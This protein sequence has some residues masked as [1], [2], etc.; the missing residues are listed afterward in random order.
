MQ[1]HYCCDE[2][3][4]LPPTKLPPEPPLPAAGAT[5]GADQR[6]PPQR[7]QTTTQRKEAVG[8]TPGTEYWLP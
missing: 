3:Q 7:S 1:Y 8:E 4:D 5:E 6:K 2:D